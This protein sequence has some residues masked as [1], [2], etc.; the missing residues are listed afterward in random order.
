MNS[1][2]LLQVLGVLVNLCE[3]MVIWEPV[4]FLETRRGF[5]RSN[6]MRARMALPPL[7]LALIPLRAGETSSN[8]P[9]S[10]RPR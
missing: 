9:I 4:F 3:R 8:E 6:V 2:S 1:T 7:S 5:R 10:L